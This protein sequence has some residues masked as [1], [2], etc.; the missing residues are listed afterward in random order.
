MDDADDESESRLQLSVDRADA[1]EQALVELAPDS[2]LRDVAACLDVEPVRND[3]TYQQMLFVPR[4]G[5]L[6]VWRWLQRG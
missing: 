4:T 3:D 1:L 6:R 5:E 2:D